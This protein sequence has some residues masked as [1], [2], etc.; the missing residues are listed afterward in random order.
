MP[1]RRTL[2]VAG[3]LLFVAS[4]TSLF[5]EDGSD[6]PVVRVIGLPLAD[7][8]PAMVALERYGAKM[9][10]VDYRLELLAGPELL[11]ARF[12]D[13]DV[14]I[15]LVPCP[16]ALDMFS[17]QGDFR[18]VGLV[19]RD[20]NALA[21]NDLMNAYVNLP[22]DRRERVPDEK[23]AQA[24]S[25]I[26]KEMGRPS[27]CGVPSRLSTHTVILYKY[28]KDHG[29]TLG[30]T[31]GSDGDVVVTVVAPPKAPAYL[32]AQNSR[33]APAS[34]EQ[35][36]PW[37]EMA[38]AGGF[39]H[40][41]WYSKDVMPWPGGH[42]ECIMIAKD[43]SIAK[44]EAAIREVVY[45]IHKAGRD[46]EEARR[47]GGRVLDEVV[48]MIQ[49]HVPAH[50]RESIVESL[51][52]DLNV[53][54][55][56]NLNVDQNSRDSLKQIMD[57]A[58]EG[59]ILKR[60]VDIPALA[61]GR[62]STEITKKEVGEGSRV[63]ETTVSGET[64]VG[65]GAS[66]VEGGEERKVSEGGVIAKGWI[67][68]GVVVVCVAA[69]VMLMGVFRGILK[70]ALHSGLTRMLLLWFLVLSLAPLT[71]VSLVSYLSARKTLCEEAQKSLQAVTQIKAKYTNFYF[72]RMLVDLQRESESVQ[73]VRLL[74]KLHAAFVDSHKTLEEFGHSFERERLI[75]EEGGDLAT[76]LEAHGYYD[77]MLID[78]KGNVLYSVANEDDL[79]TNI[80][81]GKY[82]R[83]HLA[84]A[85]EKALETGRPVFS[86]YERY[87]P[88]GNAVSGFLVSVMVDEEGNKIGVIVL[89]IPIEKIN[90]IMRE[91]AG[92]GKTGESY[93]IG[94]DLRMR[95]DRV[96]GEESL[97]LGKPIETKQTRAWLG[98]HG[99]V[100]HPLENQQEVLSG[101]EG[102]RGVR[103]I[104]A[105]KTI[106]VAGVRLGVIAEIDESEAYAPAVR[107]KYLGLGLLGAT[108]LVV[109]LMVLPV[110]RC[111]VRPVLALASGTERV[112]RGDL[113]TVIEAKCKHEI[114]DVARSFNRMTATLKENRERTEKEDWLKT[115]MVRLREAVSG[116]PE[117]NGLASNAMSEIATYLGAPVGALYVSEQGRK[118]ALQLA[119]S[120]AYEKREGVATSFAPGEGLVGQAVLQRQPIVVRDVP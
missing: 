103:V 86:D 87:T 102:Y 101:Y 70:T 19:H 120:Y 99:D 1:M 118:S 97:I 9:Q 77:V 15:A 110:T 106:E 52:S 60:A 53:I 111:V 82:S 65:K 41:A 6:R 49:K 20:G 85:C 39:G 50:T 75:N 74:G 56:Y 100:S 7:H 88:S 105:H 93:L 3:V 76:F 4:L 80:L 32:K 43:R 69:L 23:V 72:T 16:I 44:K 25:K 78:S 104:G 51:R 11:R 30:L 2:L 21:I 117:I 48:G 116:D 62:F 37:A 40:V 109:V 79:G 58:V 59:G 10:G 61:D 55:Y 81:S 73:N 14:D 92:L 84:A 63:G 28:L 54:N 36:L 66:P 57:L 108:L 34:F 12:R 91:R 95:C 46:L 113:D 5:A 47:A 107:L 112:D 45:S 33:A 83:T 13:E 114:G 24:Y 115:G 96:L 26:K 31:A 18:W 71:I 119:G 29:K 90:R 35:S 94:T 67:V 89:Q 27:E 64:R 22:V 68:A 42:V 17:E 8:Y 38:E 98:T